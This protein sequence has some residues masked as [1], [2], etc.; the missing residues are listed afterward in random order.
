MLQCLNCKRFYRDL[1]KLRRHYLTYLPYFF[2]KYIC[3][4]CEKSF[5]TELKLLDHIFKQKHTSETGGDFDY[6][7]KRKHYFEREGKYFGSK[8]CE[9]TSK[10]I[11]YFINQKCVANYDVQSSVNKVQNFNQSTSSGT[12]TMDYNSRVVSSNLFDNLSTNAPQTSTS[13]DNIASGQSIFPDPAAF[14]TRPLKR[15][16]HIS[17]PS[18]TVGNEVEKLETQIR[19][20]ERKIESVE[21]NLKTEIQMCKE[22]ISQKLE[23][24]MQYQL[25]L[26]NIMNDTFR[27]VLRDIILGMLS[28]ALSQPRGSTS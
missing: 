24:M 6:K 12:P 16:T 11:N 7:F 28:G 10:D 19:D 5:E 25:Q 20:L 1:Y 21:H 15:K 3:Q 27:S 23:N 2:G 17:L 22:E 9:F 13:V 14:V 8:S 18:A 4:I 26:F